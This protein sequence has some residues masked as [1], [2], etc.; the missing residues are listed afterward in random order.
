MDIMAF[1]TSVENVVSA[2]LNR[3][4]SLEY[5]S[6]LVSLV[7]PVSLAAAS[8]FRSSPVAEVLTSLFSSCG[9]SRQKQGCTSV[10]NG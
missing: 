1:T 2:Y 7:A 6:S 8:A 4:A 3:N 10:S 9:H 5:Q